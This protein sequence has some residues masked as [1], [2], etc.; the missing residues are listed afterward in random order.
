MTPEE[1]ATLRDR[2]EGRRAGSTNWGLVVHVDTLSELLD[3]VEIDIVEV[4]AEWDRKREAEQE[5]QRAGEKRARTIE[6]AARSLLI[7]V[8]STLRG[9]P[10][11]N[12]KAKVKALR[13]ALGSD[14]PNG[15]WQG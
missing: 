12:V 8:E 7:E 10:P 13:R 14:D 1:I 11:K 4:V 3:A 5:F 6:K 15:P 2:I 9:V